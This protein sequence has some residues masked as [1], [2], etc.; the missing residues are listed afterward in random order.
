MRSTLFRQEA[1]QA[2][3]ECAYGD[4]LRVDTP[5]AWVF[6][7][8]VLG[9]SASLLAYGYWGE[10]TRKTHVLGQL[11]P[12][13]GHIKVYAPE[14]GT[15]VER[16]V[17]EGQHVKKGDALF[18]LSLERNSQTASAANATAIA[19]LHE[20]RD[21][22]L[23]ELDKQGEIGVAELAAQQER[24]RGLS[25][26]LAQLE[27]E[28]VTQRQLVDS[29]QTSLTR[30]E[31]YRDQ[32]FFSAAHVQQKQEE[33]LAQTAKLQ[34]LTRNRVSLESDLASARQATRS[35]K[36]QSEKEPAALRR[37]IAALEAQL[38]EWESRRTAVIT[39]PSDGL[40]TT[41]LAQQGQVASANAPLMSILPAGTVLRAELFVPSR[42]IGF[43][44][45]RQFVA[46]R[47]AAFPYQSF[48][49]YA[50][51]ITEISRTL[52]NPQESG[53]ADQVQ[54]PVYRV[55]VE[56]ESQHVNAYGKRMPLQSGMALEADVSLER[57]RLIDWVFAPLL[58]ITGRV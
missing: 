24:A 14:G 36:L 26:E 49:S 13:M 30:Y 38:S 28:I 45:V 54:E 43:V 39:A 48:G 46:I 22:L 5:K 6:V 50:G 7:V 33:L 23:R 25:A 52:I 34:A 12:T 27:Q 17:Q 8:L 3:R 42:S 19:K 9:L 18:V 15:I 57:R 44:S 1:L 10:F 16:R 11:V 31:R 32:S 29:A 4:T 40:A 37:E 55:L 58:S 41:I 51:K 21:S 53:M 56:L 20:R 2:K 47:Y 35:K